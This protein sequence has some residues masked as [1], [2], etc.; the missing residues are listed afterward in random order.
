MK[1]DST[2]SFGKK[3]FIKTIFENNLSGVILDGLP[4]MIWKSKQDHFL[5]GRNTTKYFSYD[6]INWEPYRIKGYN[7]S[8]NIITKNNRITSY[9]QYIDGVYTFSK[10]FYY[11][12]K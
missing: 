4:K 12:S 8:K 11:K 10:Y 5:I 6:S 2:Y 7:E 9:D 1:P 3:Y